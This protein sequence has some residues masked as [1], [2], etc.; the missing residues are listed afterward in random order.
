MLS[1]RGVFANVTLRDDVDWR[2]YRGCYHSLELAMPPTRP[3]TVLLDASVNTI[4]RRI[5]RRGR[6]EEAAV[7]REYIEKLHDAHAR[8]FDELPH[9]KHRVDAS[10]KPEDV[11]RAL[12]TLLMPH[13]TDGAGI[14]SGVESGGDDSSGATIRPRPR[15]ELHR[16]HRATKRRRRRTKR[17]RGRRR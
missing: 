14:E 5:E 9:A 6:A 10:A 16:T 12:V 1:D 3:L 13:L 7:P 8:F 2:V 17:P 15:E 4:M 11:A